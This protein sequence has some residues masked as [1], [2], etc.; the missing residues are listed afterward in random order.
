MNQFLL[1]LWL[2]TSGA[3]T[4]FYFLK[5]RADAE[6]MAARQQAEAA[7]QKSLQEIA[8][9]RGES[10]AAVAFAQQALEQKLAELAVEAERISGHY[11]KE[12]MRVHEEMTRQLALRRTRG[13][14]E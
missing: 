9:A 2:F 4:V 8:K 7:R 10:D 12:A 14:A 6:A 5:K 11:E 3:L 1:L 13:S